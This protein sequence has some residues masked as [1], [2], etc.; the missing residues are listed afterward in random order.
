MT[1]SKVKMLPVG[2]EAAVRIGSIKKMFLKISQNSQ[3]KTFIGSS[4]LIK[5]QTCRLQLIKKE[6][7][8]QVLFCEFCKTPPENA[9]VNS[10]NSLKTEQRSHQEMLY[11]IYDL[12]ISNISCEI[13][14]KFTKI[15]E[16]NQQRSFFAGLELTILLKYY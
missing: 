16:R 10:K 2:T 15:F 1:K 8:I 4:F 5:M 3:E 7:P 6:T 14:W 11:E 9:S 13:T 12:R